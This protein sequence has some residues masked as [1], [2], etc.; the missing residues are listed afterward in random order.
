MFTR[1]RR[2]PRY[3]PG[4][5]IDA[6]SRPFTRA[7][8]SSAAVLAALL[9]AC[10]GGGADHDPAAAAAAALAPAA[11]GPGGGGAVASA[12]GTCSLPNFTAGVL[13]RVNQFRAAGANCGSRGTYAPAPGLTWHPALSQAADSHSRDM[14]ANNFFSHT[15]ANGS[16]AG[17]RITA[18]GYDWS[19]YGENIAAGQASINEVVDGW[20]ASDGHCANIMNAALAD[21]GVACVPGSASTAYRTYWTMDLGRSR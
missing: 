5:T 21:I 11:S 20:M 1:D 7:R 14:V 9:A 3:A 15:G 12:T 19:G 17:Q 8:Q 4:V 16:S 6:S 10:G 13:A 18:V 2:A